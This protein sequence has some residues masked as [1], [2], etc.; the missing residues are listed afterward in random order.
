MHALT[1]ALTDT[2]D[3]REQ[4]AATFCFVISER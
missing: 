3:E 4:L 2:P 1:G